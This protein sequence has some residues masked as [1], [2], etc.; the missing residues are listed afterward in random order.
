MKA[1]MDLCAPVANL[2]NLKSILRKMD[3]FANDVTI[4]LIHSPLG[5]T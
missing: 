2:I 5:L 1:I 4:F 3:M